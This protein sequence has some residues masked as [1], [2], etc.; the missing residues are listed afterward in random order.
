MKRVANRGRCRE[1]GFT[2]IELLVVVLILAILLAIALPSF[3]NQQDKAKETEAKVAL[4]TAY[5]VAKSDA[6]DHGNG[7]YRAPGTIEP[8]IEESEPE[9]GDVVLLSGAEDAAAGQMGIVA[10]G[11]GN[12]HLATR[13][14]AGSLCELTVE[15]HGVP[16]ISC[17]GGDTTP[18]PGGGD[19]PPGDGG[20]PETLIAELQ[21]TPD[22]IWNQALYTIQDDGTGETLLLDRPAGE[23]EPATTL[24]FGVSNDG[25]KLAFY[26]LRD[27]SGGDDVPF[28]Y[29]G[30]YVAN[31]DGSNQQ[32][33]ANP[34]PGA[35]DVPTYSKVVAVDLSPNGDE[36]YVA[37]L[38]GDGT[39]HYSIFR[40]DTVTDAA[41][42]LASGASLDGF[43]DSLEVSPSGS[44][45]AFYLSGG[46]A[47]V[48]TMPSAGGTPQ[49]VAAEASSTRVS[50]TPSG[51]LGYILS[52]TG[53]SDPDFPW[54][55]R[56]HLTTMD[57]DGSNAAAVMSDGVPAWTLVASY[58]L[59]FGADRAAW[60]C[61]NDAFTWSELYTFCVVTNGG[62]TET[63]TIVAGKITDLQYLP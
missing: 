21:M 59:A 14:S 40:V 16:E 48:Y 26:A 24:H 37:C 12:L 4:N 45:L 13:T 39:N 47:G 32:P 9:F 50:W 36:L 7:D 62:A 51:Q 3:L 60:H 57:A 1:S 23:T 5:K 35:G 43:A 55:T 61:G 34:C 44:S 54:M 31:V 38:F 25:T 27:T 46:T 42:E 2:L 28:D 49:L 11:G 58:G 56:V 30:L 41:T 53:D 18:P 6:T 20:D 17:A 22:G 52:N 29:E 63:H 10:S 15:D 19:P 8:L 33:V